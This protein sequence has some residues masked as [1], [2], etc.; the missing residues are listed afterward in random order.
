MLSSI[1]VKKPFI[2]VV[3]IEE[4]KKD[5]LTKSPVFQLD[6]SIIMCMMT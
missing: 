4:N 3:N 6:V 1:R 5:I 2:E